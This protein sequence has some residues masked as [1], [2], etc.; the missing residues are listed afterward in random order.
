VK[1]LSLDLTKFR[2]MVGAQRVTEC[3]Y[4]FAAV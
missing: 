4:V 3:S 2:G 1:T